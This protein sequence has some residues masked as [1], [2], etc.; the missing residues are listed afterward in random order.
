MDRF[1]EE[2][3]GLTLTSSVPPPASWHN[4]SSSPNVH[5]LLYGK[6][7]GPAGLQSSS[8][9]GGQSLGR[10][11]E[12]NVASQSSPEG[13]GVHN[14]NSLTDKTKQVITNRTTSPFSTP[15]TPQLGNLT[16]HMDTSSLE[17]FQRL[18]DSTSISGVYGSK[19]SS[20]TQSSMDVDVSISRST[21]R[22][23]QSLSIDGPGL[24]K[25][26]ATAMV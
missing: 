5:A 23:N 22:N 19:Q 24:S 11:E 26:E 20:R 2:G 21:V 4:R 13:E 7:S 25:P 10:V 6:A 1:L 8:G 9:S 14:N 15:C 12:S 18:S 3:E 17:S 16:K